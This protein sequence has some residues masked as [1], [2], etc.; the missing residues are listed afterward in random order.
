MKNLKNRLLSSVE[1]H[2]KIDIYGVFILFPDFKKFTIYR[3]LFELQNEG[4][5]K[6]RKTRSIGGIISPNPN[7]MRT[8]KQFYEQLFLL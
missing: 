3:L 5:L 2:G 8:E 6:I 7:V 4:W 1:I